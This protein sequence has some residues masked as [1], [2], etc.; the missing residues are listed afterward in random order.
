MEAAGQLVKVLEVATGTESI[1]LA[2]YLVE[3]NHLNFSP[4][5][6][7]IALW[8]LDRS[9]KLFE[10]ATGTV[11]ATLKGHLAAVHCLSFSPDGTRL[12]TG[13]SDMTVKVWDAATGNDRTHI[14]WFGTKDYHS[15]SSVRFSEDGSRVSAVGEEI[16]K[17]WEL[18]TGVELRQTVIDGSSLIN[19]IYSPDGKLLASLSPY[20]S[21]I[22]TWDISNGKLLKT[23]EGHPA[24]IRCISFS[25]DSARLVSGGEDKAI[26]IWDL[27]T[28][29]ELRTLTGHPGHVHFAS[30]SPDG[31][32]IASGCTEGFIKLW[33]SATGR[34]LISVEGKRGYNPVRCLAFAPDGRRLAY[35][36]SDNVY[37]LDS[38]TGRK[39][40]TIRD[41]SAE[42][43]RFSPDGT[44][45]ATADQKTVKIWDTADGSELVSLKQNRKTS[46][47]E[48]SPNGM[49]LAAV[50]K[51][52]KLWNGSQRV[53]M[54]RLGREHQKE[55][56]S[57]GFSREGMH[58]VMDFL[59]KES[60]SDFEK[61][62][63]NKSINSIDGRWL[64]VLDRDAIG[65]VLLVDREYKNQPEELQR[66]KV[67]AAPR[68]PWHRERLDVALSNSS[69]YEAI[70]HAAWL[71]KLDPDDGWIYDELQD[72]C[73]KAAAADEEAVPL[74]EI[75]I[76]MLKL[77]RGT[78]LP[79]LDEESA[80][81][82]DSRIW[83]IVKTPP[84]DSSSKAQPLHLQRMQDI[85]GKFHVWPCMRTLGVV[86][87]RLGR[88][89]EA[90]ESL[91]ESQKLWAEAEGGNCNPQILAFIAMSQHHLG[92]IDRT[93]G[94]RNLIK[95]GLTPDRVLDQEVQLVLDEL[96][97][98]IDGPTGRD[99]RPLATLADFQKEGAFEDLERHRWRFSHIS[100][101]RNPFLDSSRSEIDK[102]LSNRVSQLFILSSESP[103]SG[104]WCLK[105]PGFAWMADSGNLGAYE[106]SV[107][108]HQTLAVEPN[109]RYQLTG[110]IRTSASPTA[111][112]GAYLGIVG[113]KET[114]EAVNGESDW[115]KV[116]LE[117]STDNQSE[118]TLGCLVR[119]CEQAVWFDQLELQKID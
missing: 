45:L 97:S 27:V 20:K 99:A 10:V 3:A 67:L 88:F 14:N 17:E 77:P 35:G 8:S 108:A 95:S 85:C 98:T 22:H 94:T 68:I 101:S 100:L 80:A 104:E 78:D 119:D 50:N 86:Q 13:S 110:W 75:A 54:S 30:F 43:I 38:I 11:L 113:R 117:F 49:W 42:C 71:M 40:F 93:I 56:D 19:E 90:I 16:I 62:S 57:L 92:E 21:V 1:K 106:Q 6:T 102:Q 52:I 4:D 55:I 74:P 96:Q 9:I 76:E 61:E 24:R 47:L 83:E 36:D 72:L 23:L 65:R 34:L 70:F 69:S 64:A 116:T 84:H 53:E 81:D 41:A 60:R 33:D 118:I 59:S 48:F 7:R 89:A 32:R 25:P 66:R 114:S 12:A 44:R 87:Y 82:W 79:Q 109:S 51:D 63:S 107:M 5:G 111:K 73:R 103:H 39:L 46:Y 18:P 26:K 29:T 115:K 91:N 15:F 2:G 28:G 112:Y 58:S 37:I 31:S 105:W